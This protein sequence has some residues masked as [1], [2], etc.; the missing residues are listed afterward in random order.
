MNWRHIRREYD[1]NRDTSTNFLSPVYKTLL[2]ASIKIHICHALG[3]S[4]NG[5]DKTASTS[6]PPPPQIPKAIAFEIGKDP[7][8]Q[9]N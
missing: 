6:P 2:S 7:S 3:P 5:S 9:G 4:E 1:V 8:S